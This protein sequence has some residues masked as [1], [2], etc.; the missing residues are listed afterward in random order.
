MA[1]TAAHLS[2]FSA[3]DSVALDTVSPSRYLM[4]SWRHLSIR[5]LS[6]NQPNLSHRGANNALLQSL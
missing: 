5:H 4:G 3:G 2:L 6:I 1:L